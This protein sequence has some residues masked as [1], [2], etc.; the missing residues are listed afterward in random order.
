[1][2]NLS[3]INSLFSHHKNHKNIISLYIMKCAHQKKAAKGMENPLDD[4]QSL[5]HINHCPGNNSIKSRFSL[6]HQRSARGKKNW[7]GKNFRLIASQLCSLFIHQKLPTGAR[8]KKVCPFLC[9]WRQFFIDMWSRENYLSKVFLHKI[10]SWIL[11][12]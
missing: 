3:I 2:F 11:E 5:F 7:K 4:K 1:M 12:F 9:K 6:H 8:R 10:L